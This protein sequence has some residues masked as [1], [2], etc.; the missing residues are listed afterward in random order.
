[1]LGIRQR[2]ARG[3][4]LQADRRGDV[5]GVH[6]LDFGALAGVHLQQAADA[7]VAILVRHEHLVAR[8]QRARIDPEEG[9]IADERVVQDLEGERRE[10]R[11]VVGLA[12]HGLAALALALDRRHF[13]GR[14]H[15]FDDGVEHR[16]HALVLEG[17]S[18]GHQAHFV[19]QGA[20]PQAPLDLEVGEITA[21]EV[22]V[23]QL[24]VALGGR[25]DHLGAPFLAFLEH[26]GRESRG[27]RTSCPGFHRPRRSTSS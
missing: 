3:H 26:V 24:F 15:V 9:Q 8:I 27:T 11:V 12:R 25:L 20:R 7:L 19:L 14:G 22:L 10:R 13:H 23:E 1:M 2:V 4:V 16:L 5:A 21:L 18:A 6:F 17:R